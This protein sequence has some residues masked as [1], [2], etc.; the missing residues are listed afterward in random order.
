MREKM[1]SVSGFYRFDKI[2]REVLWQVVRMY[3]VGVNCWVELKAC[4]LIV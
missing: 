3:D 1:Q 4:T 2:N